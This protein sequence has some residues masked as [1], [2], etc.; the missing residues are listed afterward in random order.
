MNIDI[1]AYDYG[2]YALD[3]GYM[4]PQM[5]A[6]HLIVEDGRVAFVDTGTFESV[7]LMLAALKHLGLGADAVDY[8]ILTHVHLDHAG[9]AGLLMQSLPNAKLVA[10]PRAAPH[11]ADPAKLW[12]GVVAVYGEARA[13]LDYDELIPI[14][15][16]RIIVAQDGD[17]VSLAG[18]PLTF[19]DCPG[20]AKHHLF[21][22]DSGAAAIFS[23]DT[24]GL[25]YRELDQGDEKYI[26]PTTTPTQFDP[27]A[28][29]ASVDRMLALSP[30]AIYLTHYAEITDIQR[31]GADL[32]RLVS[33]H[34]AL[35]LAW[36]DC[37]DAETR[38]NALVQGVEEL[39]V[40][41]A[42]ANSGDPTD[43]VQT[44]CNDIPLNAQGLSAW[45]DYRA[46]QKAR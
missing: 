15:A 20:H 9:G 10:H 17:S 31:M 22:H 41:E 19:Y 39:V 28:F 27:A 36:E 42:E 45:L 40:K 44:L 13:K 18:R 11:L 33:A 16:A 35:A 46:R 34:E 29:R 23:G 2:I 4:R 24:F 26:F 38:D 12:A 14:A 7:P 6:I 37:A 1:Q 3:S 32:K 8:V 21:V 43:W 5:A 30:R 25:S